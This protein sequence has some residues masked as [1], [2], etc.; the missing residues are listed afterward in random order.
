M[1]THGV[2]IKHLHTCRGQPPKPT[3]SYSTF[4]QQLIIIKL[5]LK[6]L[7]LMEPSPIVRKSPFDTTLNLLNLF[8]IP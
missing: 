1:T 2:M 5:F 8:Q 4:L 3:A 6:F 7:V